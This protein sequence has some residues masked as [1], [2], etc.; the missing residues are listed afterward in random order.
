MVSKIADASA[1]YAGIP[2]GGNESFVTTPQVFDEVNHIKKNHDALSILIQTKRLAI[3][4]PDKEFVNT[5]I[6]KSKETGDYNQLSKEDISILALALEINGELI[7]DDFAVSNVAKN[8]KIMI[9]PVMTLGIKDVGNWIHYCP[10][11]RKNFENEKECPLC[12]NVLKRKLLK[13]KSSSI[14]LNK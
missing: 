9:S 13:G 10:G 6:S 14:P 5:I 4:E 1:F 11:C 12:G 8:L 2:F 3:R 7:T